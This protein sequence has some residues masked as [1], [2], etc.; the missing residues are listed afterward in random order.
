[1]DLIK[2]IRNGIKKD[3]T[4]IASGKLSKKQCLAIEDRIWRREHELENLK[5]ARHAMSYSKQISPQG[6]G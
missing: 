1:M 3:R 4:L 2:E 6:Q 5:G